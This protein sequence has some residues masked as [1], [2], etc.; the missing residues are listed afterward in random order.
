[1]TAS[2]RC[3]WFVLLA[4]AG[5]AACTSPEATRVRG[6]GPGADAGNRRTLTE[7]QGR[8][9]I[10]YGTPCRLPTSC[11]GAMASAVPQARR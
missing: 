10:Y 9:R 2:R 11:A 4:V 8:A 7:T 3:S 5:V 1:M 6:G